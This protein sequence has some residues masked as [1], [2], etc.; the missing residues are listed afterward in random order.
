M[1]PNAHNRIISSASFRLERELSWTSLP[2][3][4]FVLGELC[5]NMISLSRCVCLVWDVRC[6]CVQSKVGK[7]TCFHIWL[8]ILS[9]ITWAERNQV[10][11]LFRLSLFSLLSFFMNYVMCVYAIKMGRYLTY[12]KLVSCNHI[13]LSPSVKLITQSDPLHFQRCR[14]AKET[15]KTNSTFDLHWR[16]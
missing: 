13:Q 5:F 11:Q 8:L 6:L 9:A 10:Y 7:D 4:F 3:L 2:L 16:V 1:A 14:M 15:K 12:R